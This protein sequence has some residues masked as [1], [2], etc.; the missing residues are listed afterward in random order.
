M[1]YLTQTWLAVSNDATAT[2]GGYRY[3]RQQHA[4]Q[5]KP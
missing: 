1:G 5:H 3:H 4:P 2:V